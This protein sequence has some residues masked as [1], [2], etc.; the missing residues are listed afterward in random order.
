LA[1]QSSQAWF[2]VGDLKVIIASIA[3][4][5]CISML[6][7]LRQLHTETDFKL[8][9]INLVRQAVAIFA[10]G[11]QFPPSIRYPRYIIIAPGNSFM[12][13]DSPDFA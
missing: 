3:R 9:A 8:A 6:G 13:S 4:V 5:A 1:S 2:A 10:A 11:D 7:R 12:S